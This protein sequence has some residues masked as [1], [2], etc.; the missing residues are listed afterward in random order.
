MST[1]RR[2]KRSTGLGT[3]QRRFARWREQRPR[4][5]RIPDSLWQAAAALYPALSLYSIATAL[6]LDSSALKKHLTPS[7]KRA[8]KAM[9]AGQRF[10]DITA[11]VNPSNGHSYLLEVHGANGTTVQVRNPGSW[12][13][14]EVVEAVRGILEQRG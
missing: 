13:V 4:L 8:A 10:L 9:T 5:M 6:H 2:T 1:L 12:G 14:A 7:A 3:V 11:E